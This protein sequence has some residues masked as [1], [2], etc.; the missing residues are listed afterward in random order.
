MLRSPAEESRDSQRDVILFPCRY[1]L[2]YVVGILARNLQ[3]GELRWAGKYCVLTGVPLL[4]YRKYP[5]FIFIFFL[6]F[7][8][9][10]SG[11]FSALRLSVLY[12]Q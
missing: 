7:F 11:I 5:L 3:A 10:F 2:M 1:V 4:S 9:T 6:L 8:Y 12:I